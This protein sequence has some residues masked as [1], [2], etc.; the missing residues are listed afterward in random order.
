MGLFGL[1]E[2]AKVPRLELE[3]TSA[4]DHRCA[5]CYNVWNAPGSQYPRGALP[6]A[7]YLA[8]LERLVRQ[9]GAR[10]LVL[11]G[12]EPLLHPDALK[13]AEKAVSLVSR[14]G[15]GGPPGRPHVRLVTN[16][17]HV[18]PATAKSLKGIGISAV[19]L[20]LLASRREKHDALKGVTS[21]DDTLRALLNLR[22]VGLPV[23]VCFVASRQN[24]GEL[25]DV[26]ELCYGLGVRML[27]YNRMCPSGGAVGRIAELVPEVEEVEADLEVAERLGRLRGIAVATAMPIPPCLVRLERYP[28]IR[29][30]FC[31]VG[32]ASPNLVVD[33]LGNVR[34]CNLSSTILGNVL[35]TDF[36]KIRHAAFGKRFRRE[37]PPMCRGCAYQDSCNGGCKAS[38]LAAY[39]SAVKPEPFLHF[40]LEGRR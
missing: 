38:A 21:F 25:P 22:D 37:V 39:G 23:Q 5:H 19:Q 34:P 31:S 1:G 13:V 3:L 9:S 30:G 16:G 6:T 29:F 8:M 33:P 4:C 35:K 20:T 36:A 2:D 12:G 18:D 27:V 10:E 7:D 40:A 14:V 32:S 26:L 15:S 24:A 28:W 17:S 11:T